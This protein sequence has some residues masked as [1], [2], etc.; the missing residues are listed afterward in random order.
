[1]SDK[2]YTFEQSYESGEVS[3]RENEY[4][5][6]TNRQDETFLSVSSGAITFHFSHLSVDWDD[7]GPYSV[8]FYNGDTPTQMMYVDGSD[9][10][11]LDEMFGE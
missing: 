4:D 11:T 6:E 7:E 5:E 1:M 3:I 2:E 10:Q 9:A 8:W